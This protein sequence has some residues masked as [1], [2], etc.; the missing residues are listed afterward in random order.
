M[1]FQL[2][3]RTKGKKS[4][5]NFTASENRGFNASASV[6]LTDAI[7]LNVGKDRNRVTINFGN[8]LRWVKSHSTKPKAKPKP[9]ARA[10]SRPKSS[11]PVNTKS[12]TWREIFGLSPKKEKPIESP[13]ATAVWPKARLEEESPNTLVLKPN[14]AIVDRPNIEVIIPEPSR[15]EEPAAEPLQPKPSIYYRIAEWSAILFVLYTIIGWLS[16]IKITDI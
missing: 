13:K 1:A 7:T 12:L 8:G 2:R 11:Q 6:K 15:F 3:K 9:K 10:T 5:L 16:T 4:W 14:D